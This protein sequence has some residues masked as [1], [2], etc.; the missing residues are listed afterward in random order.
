MLR[1]TLLIGA[2]L[3]A[4]VAHAATA[5][6]KVAFIGDDMLYAWQNSGLFP[7]SNWVGDG[8]STT[9][10][11]VGSSYMVSQ[12]PAVI[13]QHPAIVYI[14]AGS[15]DMAI[16]IPNQGWL[17]Q[18]FAANITN[19]VAQARA[20]NI[21][22][23]LTTVPAIYI[24]A[25]DEPGTVL[26]FNQWIEQFGLAN[27]IPVVNLHDMLCGCVSATEQ[28]NSADLF[29]TEYGAP[30]AGLPTDISFEERLTPAGYQL[31]TSAAQTAITTAT[32]TMGGG[33]LSN[34]ASRPD[35]ANPL[36]Q[37]NLVPVGTTLQFTPQAW[38]N[39]GPTLPL[40]NADLNGRVGTW[41]S[42]NPAVMVV[43]QDGL[44]F[45]LGAGQAAITFQT[46]TGLNFSEWIM[47]VQPASTVMLHL[48]SPVAPSR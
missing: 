25:A 9:P 26:L 36:P 2:S 6:P 45:A 23:I 30:S 37:Q 39:S 24:W 32:Y 11:F 34:A 20:A 7:Q 22:V 42:S 44:A 15:S 31:L 29:L 46:N 27:N 47:Y 33:Y 13:A 21:K 3:F 17:L 8:F 35:E 40:L 12:F 14:M 48:R 19:I 10:G 18:R 28:L 38:F 16:Y 4:A 1:A 41:A 5:V 43:D